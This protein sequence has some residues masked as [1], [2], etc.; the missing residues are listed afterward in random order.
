MRAIRLLLLCGD[1]S[2]E[3]GFQV[4]PVLCCINPPH[5]TSHTHIQDNNR[6]KRD[7]QTHTQKEMGHC[8]LQR[9]R[10][11]GGRGGRGRAHIRTAPLL[12]QLLLLLVLVVALGAE[13]VRVRVLIKEREGRGGKGCREG[14]RN[15]REGR[16]GGE[17]V[18]W[19]VS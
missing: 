11:E 13:M 8:L 14:A 17:V 5:D 7:R 12:P 16:E 3:R 2:E 4:V 9:G 6:H 1:Q 10:R 18:R 19:Y 15:G